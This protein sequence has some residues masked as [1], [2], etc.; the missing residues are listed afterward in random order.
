MKSLEELQ[1][2]ISDVQSLLPKV[3]T[4]VEESAR[5][6]YFAVKMFRKIT[7]RSGVRKITVPKRGT[8]SADYVSEATEITSFKEASYSTIDIPAKK[9]G[10]GIKISQEVIDLKQINILNDQLE[11]AGEA[12][13]DKEDELA[14][15]EL[16]GYW[17]W[18]VGDYSLAEKTDTLTGQGA[19]SVYQ[20]TKKPFLHI[21][22]A[23]KASDESAVTVEEVDYKDGKVKITEDLSGDNLKITYY[24]T[25]RSNVYDPATAGTLAFD[26]LVTVKAQLIAKKYDPDIIV[27]HPDHL[28]SILK[29][30]RFSY[31]QEG[32]AILK[33]TLGVLA[34]LQIVV[35]DRMPQSCAL[36]IDIDKAGYFVDFKPF[37]MKK[38]D[39]PEADALAIFFY[40]TVGARIINEDAIALIVNLDSKSNKGL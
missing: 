26:D 19:G 33:G 14:M 20:L 1:V 7:D 17:D 22:S 40:R 29:D 8:M 38:K 28:A 34:G 32:Q 9:I 12:I 23:I 25:V 2:T 3:L 16:L 37:T 30:T 18:S 13:G 36:V 11:E 4:K 6:K 15:Y 27:V 5:P 10:M 24:Y 21:V 39:L 31:I 35:S